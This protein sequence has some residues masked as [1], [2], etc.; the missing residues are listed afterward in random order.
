MFGDSLAM[1]IPD[2]IGESPVGTV[3]LQKKPVLE[4]ETLDPWKRAP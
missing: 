2:V 3:T 4:L 1:L